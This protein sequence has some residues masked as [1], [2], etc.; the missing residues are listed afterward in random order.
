VK[1]AIAGGALFTLVT[2]GAYLLLPGWT[3][4]LVEKLTAPSPAGLLAHLAAGI[5]L[6]AVAAGATFAR[7]VLFSRAAL[8]A[9][10]RARRALATSFLDVRSG[11]DGERGTTISAFFSEAAL[12]ERGLLD[13]VLAFL[14]NVV[15]VIA[16]LG[17]MTWAAPILAAV[18]LVAAVP[19]VL[20]SQ[21]AG[22][23]MPEALEETRRARSDLGDA[24]EDLLVGREELVALG[25]PP[26]PLGRLT[27]A[28][29]ALRSAAQCEVFARAA[30]PL[31]VTLSSTLAAAVVLSVAWGLH[32]AGRLDSPSLTTFLVC[33]GVSSAH[34]QAAGS[35]LPH[36]Q[37]FLGVRRRFRRLLAAAPP[38]S[39]MPIGRDVDRIELV[40]VGFR[41]ESGFRLESV[42][43]SA[44]PGDLVVVHGPSGSGKSTLLRICA[45]LLE[46]RSGEVLVPGG[47]EAPECLRRS[48]GR[49]I[50]WLRQ[51]PHVFR[52]S[53][54][55]NL[56]LAAPDASD[57]DARQALAASGAPDLVASL[58]DGLGTLLRPGGVVLSA[59]QRQ[60][61]ALA[62]VLLIRPSLLLLDE[63]T[64]ALDAEAEETVFATL[65]WLAKRGTGVV[66]ATHR[67]HLDAFATKV[68]TL[69]SPTS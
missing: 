27:G 28:A 20:A 44:G 21:V 12:L 68:V 43:L 24:L 61:V 29:A 1:R 3:T 47:G 26:G 56:R 14:P 65:R 35:S 4:R 32:A 62:R 30:H 15:L 37:V 64:A 33:L 41:W 10:E 40:G 31:R 13:G 52:G 49:S 34:V 66:V 63:P 53:L 48:L 39:A 42:H 51:E 54:G 38:V 25:T 17:V 22:A 5:G 8:E 11:A 6:V 58:P 18:L 60:R 19:L 50:G 69:P 67:P 2:G 46:A 55:E 23:A 16:L 45:G 9:G 59:G 57:E 7:E 36:L